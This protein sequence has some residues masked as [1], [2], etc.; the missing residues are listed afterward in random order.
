MALFNT[1]NQWM[2]VYLIMQ[3]VFDYAVCMLSTRTCYTFLSLKLTIVSTV[4][5]MYE[6]ACYFSLVIRSFR[7]HKAHRL[8]VS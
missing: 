5:C 8:N 7:S 1:S 2:L 3:L 6:A 4:E